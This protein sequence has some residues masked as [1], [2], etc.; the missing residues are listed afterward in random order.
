MI[1]NLYSIKDKKSE[2]AAPM[3]LKDH[4]Q[5]KR[6]FDNQVKT[7]PFLTNYPED[8]ELY[9]LSAKFDTESGQILP[10]DLPFPEFIASAEEVVYGHKKT[11]SIPDND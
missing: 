10:G 11:E 3:P 4:N 9:C 5:G 8:F 6:W 7:T 2:F 1:Y